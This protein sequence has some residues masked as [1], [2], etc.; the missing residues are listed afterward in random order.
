METLGG[1]CRTPLLEGPGGDGGR[2][3]GFAKGIVGYGTVGQQE[4]RSGR[5]R[6]VVV[7][8]DG[9]SLEAQGGPLALQGSIHPHVG[10]RGYMG[11][12]AV[13]RTSTSASVIGRTDAG[14]G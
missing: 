9:W 2:W 10:G 12:Q 11:Q 13:D 8:G 5:Q 4:T 1:A 14:Q 7:G 3:G 6:G